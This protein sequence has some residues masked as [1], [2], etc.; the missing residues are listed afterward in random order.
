MKDEWWLEEEKE[1][2]L[3]KNLGVVKICLVPEC[4]DSKY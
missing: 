4:K 2:R 1:T 3:S